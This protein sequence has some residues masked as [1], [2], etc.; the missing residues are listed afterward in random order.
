MLL[1]KIA[2]ENDSSSMLKLEKGKTLKV[3]VVTH[4]KD[5]PVYY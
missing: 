1:L 5:E 4:L 3:P 2:K